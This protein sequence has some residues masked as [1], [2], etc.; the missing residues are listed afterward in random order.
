MEEKKGIGNH[1]DAFSVA[2]ALHSLSEFGNIS[3]V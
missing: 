2:I 1:G 3:F